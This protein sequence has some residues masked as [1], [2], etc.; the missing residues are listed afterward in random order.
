MKRMIISFVCCLFAMCG[1]AGADAPKPFPDF[2]FKR[3]KPP[4]TSQGPRITV[5]IGPKTGEPD[6]GSV[7]QPASEPQDQANWF[8][9]QISPDIGSASAG[10]IEG[11]VNHIQTTSANP[12]IPPRLADLQN[13]ASTHNT[14]ILRATVGTRV[15]PALV[16]AVIYAE[17]SGDVAA[18]ST[19]GAQG[20]M[21]L[22]PATADRFGVADPFDA[23]QNINGGVAY[24]DWLMG[25]FDGDPLLVLAAYN[26]GEG[27]VREH[28]GV[29]PFAETRTYVPKVLMAWSV[30]RGLC[31]TPPQLASDG[32]VFIVKGS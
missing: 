24:L 18:Q 20:L 6:P 7:S 22:I 25:Q 31:R 3:V 10:R 13:I 21:Q 17:S 19:A 8:W 32:C 5:Q 2:T 4:S 15:S 30:A 11:A 1:P 12:L 26:A 23:A 29:P 28:G 14:D 16:L 27:A 9:S